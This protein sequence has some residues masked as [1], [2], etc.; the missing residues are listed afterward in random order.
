MPN[1]TLTTKSAKEV[2]NS[3]D[4]K[5]TMYELVLDYEGQEVKAKTY[6]GAIASVGWTGEVVTYEKANKAG[7]LE[8]FVKQVPK[9]NP[10]YGA[11]SGRSYG[12]KPQSDPFTMY[13]S[14]AKDLKVARITAGLDKAKE[15][16]DD[17]DAV[18]AGGYALYRER[19]DAK[20]DATEVKGKAPEADAVVTAEEVDEPV[21]LSLVD[22][23]FGTN[24]EKQPDTPWPKNS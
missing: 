21:D 2:W 3:P 20:P 23:V 11:G 5:I 22:E 13:L 9:E 4:G 19:P 14:Y 16:T 1:M 18:I 6:S 8:T 12:G 7:Q 17:L 24:P 10:A 15:Y